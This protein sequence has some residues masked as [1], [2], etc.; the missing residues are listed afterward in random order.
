MPSIFVGT[1]WRFACDHQ[2]ESTITFK[3]PMSHKQAA[4]LVSDWSEQLLH[5][6]VFQAHEIQ[7]QIEQVEEPGGDAS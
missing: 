5:I 6:N 7:A 2:G 4:T 1:L 3:I